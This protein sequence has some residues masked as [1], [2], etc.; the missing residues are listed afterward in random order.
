ML[1]VSR[2]MRDPALAGK[3]QNFKFLKKISKAKR[4]QQFKRKR[5]FYF[6]CF[7]L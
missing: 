4:K 3:V 6:F 2:Q 1:K 7:E 5:N